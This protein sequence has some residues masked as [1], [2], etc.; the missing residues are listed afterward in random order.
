MKS[1]RI[2]ECTFDEIAVRGIKRASVDNIA[3][4]MHI[5]KKTIYDLFENKEKLL[6]LA[7]KYKVGKVIESISKFSSCS[8][9][10]LD[11]IIFN[12]VHLFK[13]L[14]SVTP[15]LYK[16]VEL[17]PSIRQY[18]EFVKGS[19][20]EYG[21]KRIA[22]GIEQG[23]FRQDVDFS[24]VGRLFELQ[25]I[26]MK[27]EGGQ[28]YSPVQICCYSFMIILRGICTEKGLEYI[29]NTFDEEYIERL[30]R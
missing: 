2:L 9:N 14:S 6:L 10:V 4:R 26:T 17:F 20:L 24:I 18:T 28:K 7:L 16:E 8:R 19:L 23:Y 12:A 5:S 29:E 13:F 3:S 22:E 30:L 25:V 1:E 27:E 21:R 11:S 15:V